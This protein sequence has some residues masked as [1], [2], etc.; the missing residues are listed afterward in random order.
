M[1]ERKYLKKS[2]KIKI[3]RVIGTSSDDRY[4]F[5]TTIADAEKNGDLNTYNGTVNVWVNI[6]DPIPHFNTNVICD[7]HRYY[8]TEDAMSYAVGYDD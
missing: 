8:V 2:T 6:V 7:H 1:Q 4:E 3:L 5:E